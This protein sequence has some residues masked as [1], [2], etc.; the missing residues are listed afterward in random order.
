MSTHAFLIEAHNNKEQLKQLLDC[1]DYNENDI[2]IHVDAKSKE[3]EGIE[4]YQLRHSKL[5]KIESIPVFWG[6]YSQIKV[7]MD[8][9]KKATETD[10]YSRYH[11]ISG[12]DLPLVNQHDLHEFFDKNADKE[13]IH[14]DIDQN[15]QN[16]KGRMSQ[17]HFLRDHIDRSQKIFC[18]IEK[19]L[20]TIQKI[21]GVNRIKKS[22]IVWAKGANWFSITDECARYVIENKNWVEKTFKYTKCCDE[23]FLQTLIINSPFK[24]KLYFEPR[25]DRC[26][27]MRYVD[28]KRGNPYIFKSQDYDELINSDYIFARK[29][30]SKVD[31]Q[32]INKIIDFTKEI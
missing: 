22:D 12:G 23:I 1:L 20:I 26:G 2:F 30:D 14:Y 4:N 7:E 24:D 17:Y 3:L 15:I 6:G 18:L 10:K 9:L 28:W 31:F 13:F 32:I 19:F 5:Y 27:N 16:F 11:L 25:E 21:C 29:F 8:L